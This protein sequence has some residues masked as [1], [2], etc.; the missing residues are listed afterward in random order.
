MAGPRRINY[1]EAMRAKGVRSLLVPS[2]GTSVLISLRA[3]HDM[4]A[5][6]MERHAEAKRKRPNQDLQ[7]AASHVP[8]KPLGLPAVVAA[9]RQMR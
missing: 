5:G 6:V 2:V 7:Q 1:L 4:I 8:Q 3:T 9:L